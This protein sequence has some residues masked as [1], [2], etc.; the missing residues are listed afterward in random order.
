ML[1]FRLCRE[2]DVGA[3]VAAEFDAG[4]S[5]RNVKEDRAVKGANPDIF[6]GFGLDRKIGRLNLAYSKQGC[7]E[8]K[9]ICLVV[10]ISAPTCRIRV[11]WPHAGYLA[12]YQLS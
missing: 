8:A 10:I 2:S 3:Q 11:C 5:S 12:E 9:I 1:V 6:N 7:R 4:V